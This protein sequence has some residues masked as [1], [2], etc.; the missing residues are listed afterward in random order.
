MIPTRQTA[1]TIV[2]YK[3]ANSRNKSE[4]EYKKIINDFMRL[5]IPVRERSSRSEEK[6][7]QKYCGAAGH[8]DYKQ[9]SHK[10]GSEK[11][12]HQCCDS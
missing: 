12:D 3:R 7:G 2:E 8:S 10:P 5:L 11:S 1:T 6:P 4:K 9:V